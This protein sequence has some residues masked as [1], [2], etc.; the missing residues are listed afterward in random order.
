[1]GLEH[2]GN[3]ACRRKANPCPT[4]LRMPSNNL[5]EIQRQTWA[6]GPEAEDQ[7]PFPENTTQHPYPTHNLQRL[8]CLLII[9][10]SCGIDHTHL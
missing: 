3:G 6:P 2:D 9:H 8:P 1:M 5:W 7:L 4:S 10:G